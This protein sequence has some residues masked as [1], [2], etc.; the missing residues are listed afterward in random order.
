M[1]HLLGICRCWATKRLETRAGWQR[2]T[3]ITPVCVRRVRGSW[4][5]DA[6]ARKLDTRTQ[7][8]VLLTIRQLV[9]PLPGH[10][11]IVYSGGPRAAASVLDVHRHNS[12]G[13]KA[14]RKRLETLRHF[15]RICTAACCRI[16]I[17]L[18]PQALGHTEND[19]PHS[20]PRTSRVLFQLIC[21]SLNPA[22]FFWVGDCAGGWVGGRLIRGAPKI[23]FFV[24]THAR[25]PS[26]FERGG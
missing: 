3:G 5:R 13:R 16:A 8:T 18:K 22:L 11:P 15:R 4:D 19:G 1:S 25:R 6:R 21:S 9:L 2:S 20:T 26:A 17:T 23:V 10:P 12:V 7:Q 24:L 14:G